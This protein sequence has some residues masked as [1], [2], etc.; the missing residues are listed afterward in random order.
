MEVPQGADGRGGRQVGRADL[1]AH[2]REDEGCVDNTERHT[3]FEEQACEAAIQSAGAQ[4]GS[5]QTHVGGDDSVDVGLPGAV[6]HGFVLRR[7]AASL[8]LSPRPPTRSGRFSGVHQWPDWGVHR[9]LVRFPGYAPELNP[10][11]GIWKLAKGM[12]ANGC[13]KD[14]RELSAVIIA[15]ALRAIAKNRA[16]WAFSYEAP[17]AC[18]IRAL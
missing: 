14:R 9:G 12:L 17:A 18:P 7:A 16:G 5:R 2:D 6:S 3:P 11:E 10:D 8:R 1:A 4:R 15:R 13:P